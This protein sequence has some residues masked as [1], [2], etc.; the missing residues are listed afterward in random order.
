MTRRFAQPC[1]TPKSS[2]RRSNPSLT[3]R[4]APGSMGKSP[5]RCSCPASLSPNPCS[6]RRPGGWQAK[7]YVDRAD[8]LLDQFEARARPIFAPGRVLPFDTPV[9]RRYVDLVAKARTAGKS[10][11]TPDCQSALK[12][13]SDSHLMQS[14]RRLLLV[15]LGNQRHDDISAAFFDSSAWVSRRPGFD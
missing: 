4:S 15:S 3:L 11:P 8:S 13:G 10:F 1:W 5:G 12:F 14:R 6:Y 7:R 2:R 9:A